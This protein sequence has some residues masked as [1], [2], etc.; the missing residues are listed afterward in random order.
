MILSSFMKFNTLENEKRENT[1]ENYINIIKFIVNINN[2][3][4][5][6]RKLKLK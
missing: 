2:F 4:I 5:N 6:M 3:L 1:K